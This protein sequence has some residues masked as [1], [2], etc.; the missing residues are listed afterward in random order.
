MYEL[1]L[2]NYADLT[3][4]QRDGWMTITGELTCQVVKHIILQQMKTCTT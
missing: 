1:G 3:D 4:N 2:V